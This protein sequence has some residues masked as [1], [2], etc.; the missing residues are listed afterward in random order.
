MVF[1]VATP[2]DEVSYSFGNETFVLDSSSVES[3]DNE[4]TFTIPLTL[5]IDKLLVYFDGKPA[6][7]Y[8]V[9]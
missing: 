8:L 2:V 6:L 5:G 3:F 7:G 1:K 4:T 9:N